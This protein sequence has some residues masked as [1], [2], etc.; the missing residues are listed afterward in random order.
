MGQTTCSPILSHSIS[1]VALCICALDT[2]SFQNV[3]SHR[4]QN[5]GVTQVVWHD[6][7]AGISRSATTAISYLM[8]DE[9]LTFEDALADVISRRDCVAPNRGFCD[10]L[11]IFQDQCGS[12]LENYHPDMLRVRY[13]IQGVYCQGFSDGVLGLKQRFHFN[14]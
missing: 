8:M 9:G 5:V 4:F 13:S 7:Q 6:M 2:P 14:L 10:Q 11:R 3:E 1:S 12:K